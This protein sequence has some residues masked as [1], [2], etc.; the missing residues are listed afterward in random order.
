MTDGRRTHMKPPSRIGWESP[1]AH[2]ETSKI[3]KDGLARTRKEAADIHAWAYTSTVR[4]CKLEPAP[5]IS[6][7]YNHCVSVA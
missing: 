6:V 4:I 1:R 7:I 5:S 2:V 3:A